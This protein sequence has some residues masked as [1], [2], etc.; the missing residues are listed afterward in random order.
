MLSDVE[1]VWPTAFYPCC[2]GTC[3]EGLNW[4]HSSSCALKPENLIVGIWRIGKQFKIIQNKLMNQRMCITKAQV[5]PPIQG[6][7]I[8]QN[9]ARVRSLDALDFQLLRGSIS[10]L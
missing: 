8:D 6:K 2:A 7:V 10:G 1:A 9:K 4:P 5:F 3:V